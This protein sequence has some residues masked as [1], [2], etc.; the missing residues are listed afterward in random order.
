[1]N[2]DIGIYNHLTP[3]RNMEGF[4]F[5][6]RSNEPKINKFFQDLVT[7]SMTAENNNILDF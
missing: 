4:N 1:M 7:A 6:I 2:K 5:H 3:N